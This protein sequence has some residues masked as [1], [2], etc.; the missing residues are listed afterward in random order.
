MQPA[1]SILDSAPTA[2]SSPRVNDHVLKGA[3]AL[4]AS[5]TGKLSD[6][7]GLFFFPL[8]L[9]TLVR[10]GRRLAGR[11]TRDSSKVAGFSIF[12]TG[13]VFAAIKLSP[14][15]NRVRLGCRK[16]RSK[17]QKHGV[18][19]SDVESLFPPTVFLAGCIVEPANN[20]PRWADARGSRCG[21]LALIR[22]RRGNQLRPISPA[23][24]G[25]GKGLYAEAKAKLESG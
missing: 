7:A 3:G 20:E 24:A 14:A 5:I 1:G 6:I 12:T 15:F 17:G 10:L 21:R 8:L 2:T 16:Y 25:N 22:T 4:P 13:A 18:E 23:H 19:P 9:S 11:S